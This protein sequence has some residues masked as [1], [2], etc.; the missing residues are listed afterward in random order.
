MTCSDLLILARNWVFICK[1]FEMRNIFRSVAILIFINIFF[2]VSAQ[3]DTTPRQ[4]VINGNTFIMHPVKGG[5][6]LYSIGKQYG[7]EVVLILNN[8]PQL[9]FGLKAGDILKIPVTTQEQISPLDDAGRMPDRLL[10]HEVKRRE[11]LYSVS[12]QYGVTIDDILNFN[13]GLG[14]LRRGD[15]IRIPQWDKKSVDF[16]TADVTE[17]VKPEF[18]LHEV[19]AGETFFA[20]SRKYGIP[21]QQLQEANPEVPVLK[22]GI[23]LRIPGQSLVMEKEVQ[24]VRPVQEEYME[25]IIVSG[26]T[27]FSLTRKYNVTAERLVEL[28]P[29]LDGSFKT[30]TVVRIPM[31]PEIVED[32]GFMKYVVQKGETLFRIAQ[33]YRVTTDELITWN[34]F[35][36]YRNIIPGDTLKLI[37]GLMAE[38]P[39]T[40]EEDLFRAAHSECDQLKY[41]RIEGQ[42][43]NVVMLLPLLI[44]NNN[45]LNTDQMLD[46][47]SGLTENSFSPDSVQIIKSERGPQIKFQGNSEDFIHF[48]EGALLAVDSLRERGVNVRLTVFD[49]EQKDSRIRQLIATDKLR[50][51]DLIIGPVYPNEQKEVAEYAMRNEIPMVSPLSATDDFSRVNPWFF[52]VN[53]HRDIINE[54]TADYVASKYAK[55]NF[56]VLRTGNSVQD[57]ELAMLVREKIT[58]NNNGA[59]RFR[60]CDFQRDAL[61]GLRN[62]LDPAQKNIIILTSTNEAEVSIGMSNIH[63]LAPGYD[64]TVIGSNR[65]TQFES[66]NQEYFHDGQLEFLAPYWPDYK[67][68]VT[69]SFVSKFR[70]YFKTE[71]NQYSM[72]GYDVTYFFAE[73][74]SAFGRDFRNCVHT[75]IPQLV[76]GNYRFEKLPS[77]GYVNRGLSVISYTR[78]FRV[79]TTDGPVAR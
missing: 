30:G 13:P 65:F 74:I 58:R 75:V 23:K 47:N 73:A 54:I 46:F 61:S 72:Q 48:Y 25:H 45:A 24:T 67:K 41:N 38:Q 19:V 32:E 33:F 78:D 49:T 27:L 39:V 52:Q 60:N 43:V 20:I 68:D 51:A 5:E 31:A 6:T 26:E 44:D 55:S 34:P 37:A 62:L 7:V 36:E 9:L 69:R 79:V 56:I 42:A 28:N 10:V 63:T 12:R 71:P 1:I 15:N 21:V 70:N 77:G 3:E 17:T 29:A 18:H 22:P 76:Q 14:Q 4:V 8:N 35:L 50:N 53:P 11:T 64:I 59:G 40:G 57:N 66:I 2:A 16:E